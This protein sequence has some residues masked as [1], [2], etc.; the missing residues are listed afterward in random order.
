MAFQLPESPSE[1]NP[2]DIG[3]TPTKFSWFVEIHEIVTTSPLLKIFPEDARSYDHAS[4]IN[5]LPR[6][7]VFLSFF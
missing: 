3:V 4:K 5:I 1:L 2:I 6:I 7:L